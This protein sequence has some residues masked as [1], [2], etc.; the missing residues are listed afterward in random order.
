MVLRECHRE[1]M[2]RRASLKSTEFTCSLEAKRE[3]AWPVS[4]AV[5]S[6]ASQPPNAEKVKLLGVVFWAGSQARSLAKPCITYNNYARNRTN[7][8]NCITDACISAWEESTQSCSLMRNKDGKQVGFEIR[9]NPTRTGNSE[10]LF[11]HM[12]KGAWKS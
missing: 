7:K 5:L 2:F 1:R 8:E 10:C 3:G 6:M 12:P 9:K 4:T 11:P